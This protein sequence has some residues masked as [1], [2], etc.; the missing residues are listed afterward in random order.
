MAAHEK[1]LSDQETALKFFKLFESSAEGGV[2]KG[3]VIHV[4]WEEDAAVACLEAPFVEL[5]KISPKQGVTVEAIHK[6]LDK[7]VAYMKASSSGVVGAAYGPV[8]EEEEQFIMV[9]GWKS[10]EVECTPASPWGSKLNIDV[11][12]QKTVAR[13]LVTKKF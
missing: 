8:I 12:L 1:F 6:A 3:T 11:R 13:I 9:V 2:P 5:K 10:I 4:A 7:Y